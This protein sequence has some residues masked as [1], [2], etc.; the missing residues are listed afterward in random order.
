MGRSMIGFW[1]A[2]VSCQDLIPYQSAVS[3]IVQNTKIS[4]M[5]NLLSKGLNMAYIARHY[6][7]DLALTRRLCGGVWGLP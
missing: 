4:E 5:H 7:M 3:R 2:H 1:A 6:H